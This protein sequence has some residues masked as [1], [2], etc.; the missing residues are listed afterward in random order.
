MRAEPLGKVGSIVATVDRDDFVSEVSRV[1]DTEVTQ[2]P[3][4]DDGDQV[5]WSRR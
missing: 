3:G 1:L 5:A 4:P 2:S